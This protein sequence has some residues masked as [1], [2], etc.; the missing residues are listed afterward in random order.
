MIIYVVSDHG[1]IDVNPGKVKDT[2]LIDIESILKPED[3]TVML[4]RGSTSFLYPAPGK[5]DK[6]SGRFTLNHTLTIS[7]RHR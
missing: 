5:E 4:D 6:V 7:H 3:V 1:M 2:T